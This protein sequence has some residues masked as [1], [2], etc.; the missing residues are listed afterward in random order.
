MADFI[1]ALDPSR[2]VLMET[3]LSFV[4]SPFTAPAYNLP[5]F[6][7]GIYAQENTEAVQSLQVFTGLVG[8]SALADLAWMLRNE[9]NWFI[10][11]LNV[12][13]LVL[14]APTFLA[15]AS[16]LRSRGAQFSNL[17]GIGGL[18]VWSMPGGFTS[19]GRDGYQTVD[20]P[21]PETVRPPP[22]PPPPS[23]NHHQQSQAAPGA[24]QS[25]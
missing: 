8:A 3:V 6:L 21:T 1:Q 24:Y 22:G 9:Q 7:F 20:E 14:K 15:F 23:S 10:K 5:I 4:I 11:L 12:L 19:G 18:R 17:G 25:V 2:L 13:I 16:S